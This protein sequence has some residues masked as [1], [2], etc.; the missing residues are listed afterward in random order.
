MPLLATFFSPIRSFFEFFDKERS[1]KQA[2]FILTAILM[3]ALFPLIRANYSY[4]DDLGR[5][6]DGYHGW[7]GFG[8]YL[9]NFFSLFVHADTTLSDISPLPQ[10]I[11]V[12]ILAY[13][14][15]IAIRIVSKSLIKQNAQSEE[16]STQAH[17]GYTLWQLIATLPM[18]LSPWYL[19]CLSFKFDSPYMAL[20]VLASI[21]PMTLYRHNG[22][23]YFFV[24]LCCT[25]VVCTTYQ[26]SLA[27]TMIF[28]CFLFLQQA[29][30]NVGKKTLCR[31]VFVSITAISVALLFF[32]IF[33]MPEMPKDPYVNPKISYANPHLPALTDFIQNTYRNFM[34][35]AQML[36]AE[37]DKHHRWIVLSSLLIAFCLYAIG[38]NSL[39]IKKKTFILTICTFCCMFLCSFGVYPLMALPTFIP[40]TMYGIGAFIALICLYLA[41]CQKAYVAKCVLAMFSWTLIVFAA[42]YGNALSVQKEYVNFRMQTLLSDINSLETIHNGK[43]KEFFL[44]NINVLG[45]AP[46]IHKT[47]K[48]YPI[49]GML[50]HENF[51][52]N[53][54]AVLHYYGVKNMVM[55]VEKT[56]SPEKIPYP[57]LKDTMYHTITGDADHL[58]IILK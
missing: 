23:A 42:V 6:V 37:L 22:K 52:W 48:L 29:V 21:F 13:T 41:S 10:L 31:Y 33:L 54:Y 2:F 14:G 11:A 7:Q 20:S 39:L 40:R 9:S 56:L 17:K 15:L 43:D 32:V 8:R 18:F 45:N 57:V 53:P 28:F 47:I 1:S 26:V 16:S 51:F 34:L 4:L 25:L 12:L 44:I 55:N 49:L 27:F 50:I 58:L 30:Q 19:E 3:V 38:K 46:A 36:F 35:Y 5:A 24:L